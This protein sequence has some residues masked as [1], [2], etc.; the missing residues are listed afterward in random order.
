MVPSLVQGE[1]M[2]INPAMVSRY[3]CIAIAGVVVLFQLLSFARNGVEAIDWGLY[4]I[5]A[6]AFWLVGALPM[7]EEGS[8]TKIASPMSLISEG[9]APRKS[10]PDA[11]S[12]QD[13]GSSEVDDD[14]RKILILYARVLSK[15]IM[16]RARNMFELIPKPFYTKQDN[17]NKEETWANSTKLLEYVKLRE[18]TWLLCFG[19]VAIRRAGT[20]INYVNR[21]EFQEMWQQTLISLA[22]ESI[23]PQEQLGF[24]IYLEEMVHRLVCDLETVKGFVVDAAE[25]AGR[26]EEGGAKPLLD[27]I[28]EQ[29]LEISAPQL[30]RNALRTLEE[31]QSDS[32]VSAYPA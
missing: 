3:V 7:P 31:W 6:L 26:G 17:D 15:E 16:W 29:G 18:K 28:W 4:L 32:P 22:E 10:V 21:P 13:V 5:V 8:V 30:I 1:H 9:P 25:A 24:T 19:L 12:S 11:S 20:D 27:W 14:E 23:F 2:R